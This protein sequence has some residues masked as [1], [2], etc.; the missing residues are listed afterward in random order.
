MRLIAILICLGLVVLLKYE[1]NLITKDHYASYYHLLKSKIIHLQGWVCILFLIILPVIVFAIIYWLLCGLLY[2]FVGILISVAI[3]WFCL[4]SFRVDLTSQTSF[5]YEDIVAVFKGANQRFLA[6]ILWFFILGPIGALLYRLTDYFA[7]ILATEAEDDEH[8]YTK[9]LLHVCLAWFNWLPIRIHSL[10]YSLAGD[11]TGSFPFWLSHVLTGI[12]GNDSLQA[13]NAMTA[14]GVKSA[15][16]IEALENMTFDQT[17]I[18]AAR[19]LV[20]RVLIIELV[21]IAIFT[22]GTWVV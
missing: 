10:I 5:T 3:L 2:G 19:Q 21:I 17:H 16:G 15:E 8:E 9:E 4:G 20:D 13:R 6:V 18:N 11:F 7:A 1:N 14:L 12:A 22:L